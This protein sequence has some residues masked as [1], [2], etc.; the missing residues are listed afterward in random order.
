MAQVGTL[1][2]DL[3]AQ[4]AAFNSNIEKAARNLNTQSARMNRSLSS[5]QKNIAA[6]RAEAEGLALGLAIRGAATFVQQQLDMVGSLGEV[7]QQLGVTTR[8]LQQYRAIGAQAGVTQEDMDKGLQKLTLT[9]GKASIGAKG[10]AEAFAALGI[11]VRDSSGQIKTAG[12][13]LPEIA[14]RIA[15]ITDPA[16]RAAIEVE[17]FG[18]AGQKLDTVLTGSAQGIENYTK[19]AEEMGLILSDD[20]VA[21]ADT[22]ADK[23]A[24]VNAQLTA[25][26]AKAVA[27]NAQSILGLATAISNLTIEAVKFIGNYPRLAASLAGAAA[28]SRFGLPGAAI[29]GAAGFL[30]GDSMAQNA[31]DANMDINFRLQKQQAALTNYNRIRRAAGSPA[32]Y[33]G[34]EQE[35][36]RQTALLR[37]ATAM[38]RGGGVKP[39]ALPTAELP[40]FKAGGGGAGRSRVGGGKSDAEKAAEEAAR[41]EQQFRDQL[42][43]AND[44]LLRAKRSNA[45]NA[46]DIAALSIAMLEAEDGQVRAAI[47]AEVAAKK[48][49]VE[50]GNALLAVQAKIKAQQAEAI[51]AELNERQARERLNISQAANDN[52]R[53]LLQAVESLATTAAERRPLQLRLLE[54]DKEE[55]RLKLQAVIASR[56]A[57][58]AQ[59]Q[60]AEARL[61][62]L[63]AIYSERARGVERNTMGPLGELMRSIPQTAAEMN[64]AMQGVAANGIQAVSDG[65]ADAL[66]G[67]RSLGDVFKSVANQIIADLI[68]IQIQKAIVGTLGNLLGGGGGMPSIGSALASV[69]SQLT[70]TYKPLPGFAMGTS[71][72]PAGMAVVGENGPELVRFRGGEQV[73][74]NHRLR[75]L[76]F[77]GGGGGVAVQ[78]LP[79]PYFDVRV[80]ENISAAG[81]GLAAAGGI[82]GQRRTAY[83]NSRRLA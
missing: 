76:G 9:I 41:N 40:Q 30:V 13:I 35:L 4:T 17:L 19:R 5:V 71:S 69:G 26:I 7:A 51:T 39:V 45:I 25:N 44:E 2:V 60:I 57:T 66:T 38:A 34:A 48:Y 14:D 6:M 32:Y 67:A 72:A 62:Q 50:Q 36:N 80:Q 64:E 68:R 8:E 12:Q 58:D 83:R 65:L 82:V 79:S 33:K 56:D 74:A 16:Q 24:E 27:Q 52:Q 21:G 53:D 46:Q 63:D 29:G 20:L 37:Q 31:A 55:E 42:G 75:G 61:G 18:K 22:A 54:L 43:R 28:G 49:T 77:S 23:I 15:R 70:G 10:Q 59:R 1:T 73:I 81:P 11:S 47:E 78:V 3:I